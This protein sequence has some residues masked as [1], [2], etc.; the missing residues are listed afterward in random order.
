VYLSVAVRLKSKSF[1]RSDTRL[2]V[3]APPSVCC[4]V[5]VL[6][7]HMNTH[8]AVELPA[9]TSLHNVTKYVRREYSATRC[10]SINCLILE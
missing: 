6:V 7:T 5:S 8:D 9:D 4:L 2:V 3:S 1:D 10:L